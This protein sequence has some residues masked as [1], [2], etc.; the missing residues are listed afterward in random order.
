MKNPKLTTYP[1]AR[2]KSPSS[3]SLGK[4]PANGK[5]RGRPREYTTGRAMES[6]F[7]GERNL[8]AGTGLLMV[9]DL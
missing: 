6:H 2:T 3:F 7:R 9:R 5:R 4:H 1:F 8:G